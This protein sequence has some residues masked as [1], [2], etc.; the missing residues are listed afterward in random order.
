MSDLK[1]AI[2]D[3]A[4]VEESFRSAH[5]NLTMAITGLVDILRRMQK[6]Q[7]P[8]PVAERWDTGYYYVCGNCG[9]KFG[10]LAHDPVYCP[11]CGRKVE[12]DD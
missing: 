6:E 8:V 11:E 12:W 3:L 10:I 2:N 7:E 4:G 9:R 1:Q 5:R